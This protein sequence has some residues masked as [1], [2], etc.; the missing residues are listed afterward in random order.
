MNATKETT[1]GESE[2]VHILME[3]ILGAIDEGVSEDILSARD[4]QECGLLTSNKGLVVRAAD[5]S[6]FQITIV[7]SR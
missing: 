3:I 4:Y 6:D 5:G 2:M 7:K 1:I